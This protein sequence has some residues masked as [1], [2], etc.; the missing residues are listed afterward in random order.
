[1]KLK[2]RMM[3]FVLCVALAMTLCAPASAETAKNYA[4]YSNYMCIGD[5]IAAGCGLMKDGSETPIETLSDPELANELWNG[6]L[7]YRGYAFET[8]PNAYHTLVNNALG[9]KLLMDARSGTR[10][11][12]YRYM[13]DGVYNDFDSTNLWGQALID[14]EGNGFTLSDVDQIEQKGDILNDY[15][16]ADLITVNLGSNDV[17]T[18][19][20]LYTLM[21]AGKVTKNEQITALAEQLK[22]SGN[23]MSAFGQMLESAQSLYQ[24]YQII[25][26]MV[27]YLNKCFD[28]FKV[29]YS[30]LLKEIY[31]L[32]PDATVL[33]VGVYNPMEHITISKEL[34]VIDLAQFT[35]S[36]TEQINNFLA[37]FT[38]A[39]PNCYYA[40][41]VGTTTYDAS[42]S[43]SYFW[44]YFTLLVHPNLE[45]H[46][47]IA[48]KILAAL[49]EALK[50]PV[51]KASN[52][53]KSG[54]VTLS[55]T[56][57]PGAAKYVVYRSTKKNGTYTKIYTTTNTSYTNTKATAGKSYYYKVKAI[58]G[59]EGV[60]DSAF[61]APVYRTVDLARP[62]GLKAVRKN[63]HPSL[64][65][66]AVAG[67]DKY[68]VYRSKSATGT[69]VKIGT[70]TKYTYTD[71]NAIPG[72]TYY[73]KI[74]AIDSD[75][76]AANSAFSQY[77]Y[78]KAK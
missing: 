13:L 60:V 71:S 66:N 1:M 61:S 40:D 7:V 39:Y 16:K 45:G 36:M 8:V 62:T 17:F 53:I 63:G 14:E 44:D 76:S 12:E 58:S 28:Q 51:V 67:A 29:N 11:V 48:K 3:S 26:I 55:W 52:N 54:K 30:A 18:S 78:I 41:I 64:T 49:P 70:T 72:N 57:I 27:N 37:E 47:F 73:Y 4:D 74:K 69:F 15:K 59:T 38:S 33:L 56:A 31:A 5:S 50:A 32:N 10:A 24:L 77:V 35:A 21:D 9:S 2:F 23:I 65:W 42:L 6:G 46:Q 22:E 19:S 20:F 43:D 25:S 68:A 75:K 34:Q